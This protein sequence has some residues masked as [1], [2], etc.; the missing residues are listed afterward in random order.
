MSTFEQFNQTTTAIHR[1]TTTQHINI[2]TGI[3]SEPIDIDVIDNEGDITS[4]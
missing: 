2:F 4:V 1:M 3:Y